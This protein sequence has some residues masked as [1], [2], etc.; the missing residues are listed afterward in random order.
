M[1]T[2]ARL[3]V[4]NSSKMRFR[5]AD[6][7]NDILDPAR[8]NTYLI[9]ML[10]WMLDNLWLPVL[11]LSVRTGRSSGFHSIGCAIDIYPA[12]WQQGEKQMCVDMMKAC[13]KDPFCQGVGLGGI[14]KQ[15]RNDVIWPSPSV[16]FVLFDDNES[17]HLHVACANTADPPGYR[18]RKMG[19]TKYTG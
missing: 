9:A 8:T 11:V 13:A 1:S 17:D 14:T 15:W 5:N 7:R 19:Y 3:S 6:Q 18:A 10:Q 4:A 12:N 2:T 16:G